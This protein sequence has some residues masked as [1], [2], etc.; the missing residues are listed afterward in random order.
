MIQYHVVGSKGEYED[1]RHVLVGVF[2]TKDKA[3]SALN[4]ALKTVSNGNINSP[5]EV[6]A[7]WAEKCNRLFCDM[8]EACNDYN[9]SDFRVEEIPLNE[10]VFKLETLT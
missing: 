1:R 2:D 7:F 9:P 5:E 6:E 10:I 8:R 3:I 4:E